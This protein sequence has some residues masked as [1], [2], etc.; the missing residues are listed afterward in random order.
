MVACELSM[1]ICVHISGWI[2]GGGGVLCVCV[3]EGMYICQVCMCLS[4]SGI[5]LLFNVYM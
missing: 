5:I 1:Y 3:S 2:L 4:V